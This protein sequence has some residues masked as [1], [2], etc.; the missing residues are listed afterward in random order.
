MV[1]NWPHTD[2]PETGRLYM[3]RSGKL[4]AFSL[5]IGTKECRALSLN[6]PNNATVRSA[7][8]A[9]FVGSIVNTMMILIVAGLVQRI[10]I[11]T[12]AES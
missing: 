9:C 11:R 10:A 4:T 5:T 2:R 3:N 8:C 12:I 7:V 6:Y 1:F